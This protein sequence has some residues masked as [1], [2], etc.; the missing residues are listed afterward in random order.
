MDG[1][2]WKAAA[3]GKDTWHDIVT[4]SSGGTGVQESVATTTIPFAPVLAKFVR[5]TQ[6][7]NAENAPVW[8]IQSLR[9]F[10]AAKETGK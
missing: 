1:K 10:E 5:I 7:E 4:V 9:L 8:S 2:T 3:E 6:T